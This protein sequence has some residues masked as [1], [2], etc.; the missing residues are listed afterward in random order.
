M[1]LNFPDFSGKKEKGLGNLKMSSWNM[2]PASQYLC[3]CHNYLYCITWFS[4]KSV[5][6]DNLKIHLGSTCSITQNPIGTCPQARKLTP[7]WFLC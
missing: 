6:V 2:S 4:N 5:K 3:N 7:G 1:F